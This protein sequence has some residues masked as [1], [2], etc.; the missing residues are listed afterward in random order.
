[1]LQLVFDIPERAFLESNPEFLVFKQILVKDPKMVRRLCIN[2]L[3]EKS[4][5]EGGDQFSQ[6]I[7]YKRNNSGSRM[8]E[9][10]IIYEMSPEMTDFP[11]EMLRLLWDPKY[12]SANFGYLL[13]GDYYRT[14]VKINSFRYVAGV[15]Y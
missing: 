7:L 10:G 5:A 8:Q 1:M 6:L 13:A 15:F 2:G 12:M 9:A 3:E 11:C 14:L 4:V